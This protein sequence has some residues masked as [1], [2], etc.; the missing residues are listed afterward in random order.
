MPFKLYLQYE[1]SEKYKL[2]PT[3]DS[4]NKWC[5]KRNC[6]KKEHHNGMTLTIYVLPTRCQHI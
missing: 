3:A 5:Y 2:A 1:F 6:N 4:A